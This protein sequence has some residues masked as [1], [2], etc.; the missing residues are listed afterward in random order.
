MGRKVFCK[1][2][3]RDEEGL[4][5]PPYPGALG[6]RIYN[7]ISKQAWQEWLNHQVLIINEYRLNPIRQKDKIFLRAEMEKFLF[8]Q[9]ADIPSD[10]VPPTS[11]E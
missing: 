10:F 11:D 9:G 5:F 6:E 3:G 8:G 4:D 7:E 1:K 2:L